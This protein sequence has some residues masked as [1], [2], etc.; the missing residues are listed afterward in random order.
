MQVKLKSRWKIGENLFVLHFRG[1][2][3]KKSLSG[4]GQAGGPRD[5]KHWEHWERKY[6]QGTAF[7]NDK[8]KVLNIFTSLSGLSPT[9]KKKITKEKHSN[10]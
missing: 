5:G 8:L 3:I 9:H 1:I 10:T 4:F 6:W 2:V 7:K